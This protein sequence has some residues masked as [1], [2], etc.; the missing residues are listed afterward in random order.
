MVHVAIRRPAAHRRCSAAATVVS[1]YTALAVVGD[2]ERA[3]IDTSF[4]LGLL[5]LAAAATVTWWRAGACWAAHAAAVTAMVAV[6]FGLAA[7]GAGPPRS[8]SP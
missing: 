3:S 2:A 8:W 7:L 4:G 1:G 6:P 5:A